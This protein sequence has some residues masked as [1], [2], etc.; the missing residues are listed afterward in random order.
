MER[1]H[2]L[3]ISQP[4][5]PCST[6]HA[7]LLS[8]RWF[9]HPAS[10][11]KEN[12]QRFPDAHGISDPVDKTA[13]RIQYLLDL[14]LFTGCSIATVS[15][16]TQ[17]AIY[18]PSSEP[19]G[20]GERASA[21]FGRPSGERGEGAIATPSVLPARRL[22]KGCGGGIHNVSGV[23]VLWA[24]R[25]VRNG[26]HTKEAACRLQVADQWQASPFA[27]LALWNTGQFYCFEVFVFS[28]LPLWCVKLSMK[29]ST[30]GAKP[31]SIEFRDSFYDTRFARPETR[32]F[33]EH[34]DGPNPLG[35]KKGPV[36][37][38]F[39]AMPTVVLLDHSLG[40]ALP[41]GG[42]LQTT[43]LDRAKVRYPLLCGGGDVPR[44]DVARV[45]RALFTCSM[46]LP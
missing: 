18:P 17:V 28:L 30:F 16:E 25:P 33:P 40:M 8:S 19:T 41:L 36:V 9:S 20:A 11:P 4:G 42:G 5:A 34:G 37:H 12:P 35:L 26:P 6:Q 24:P 44:A 31:R 32:P 15:T 45:S 39:L 7:G 29:A 10:V 43:H 46:A 1:G 38:R 27:P 14:A 2:G 23:L 21:C 22:T 3:W 13:Q